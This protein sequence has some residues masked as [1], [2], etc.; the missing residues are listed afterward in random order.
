MIVVLLQYLI[1]S[2]G[3]LDLLNRHMQTPLHLA[4]KH[5]NSDIVQLLLLG[6]CAVDKI[7]E[8][9]R[10]ALMYAAEDGY[11]DIIHILVNGGI[12]CHKD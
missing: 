8:N 11:D 7:D 12:Y 4:V 2:N 3:D 10:T 6:G 5:R 9:R 1:S